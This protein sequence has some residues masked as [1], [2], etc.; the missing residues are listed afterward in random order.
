MKIAW[1][2]FAPDAAPSG[3]G[4]ITSYIYQQLI[5][6]GGRFT[7]QN[8]FDWDVILAPALPHAWP[9]GKTERRDFCWHTMFELEPL[10]RGWVDIINRSGLLWV[11]SAWCAE[12]FAAG[13][14]T[15]P[16][17]TCGYGVDQSL[18]WPEPREL[19]QPLRV[20]AWSDG[21]IG[22]KQVLRAISA[23]E[24]AE[25]PG[26]TLEVKL[27]KNLSQPYIIGKHGVPLNDVTVFS[28]D[29]GTPE[30]ADWLRSGDVLIYASGGEG[31]GLMPLEAMACGCA[32]IC[33]D[34]TGMR[35]F[36]SPEWSIPIPCPEKTISAAYSVRFD[37]NF[38]QY[39]P[40]HDAMVNALRYCNNNREATRSMGERAAEYVANNWTWDHKGPDMLSL[41][42]RHFGA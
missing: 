41:L 22:R 17:E 5:K 24:D 37:G 25:L 27:N 34:N 19:D 29:W 30:L 28:D 7:Q 23:F 31:F 39:V 38:Y 10:P 4:R 8:E 12:L 13:G 40:D 42:E 16:I 26:A 2:P 14:V 18:Y 21:L 32:V 20:L 3:Y 15:V 6:A 9:M 36:L 1:A 35:E 33:A 11:P